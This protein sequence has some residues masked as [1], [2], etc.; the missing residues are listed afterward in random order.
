MGYTK[1]VKKQLNG[2]NI[3]SKHTSSS[4]THLLIANLNLYQ[5]QKLF[6]VTTDGSDKAIGGYISQIDATGKE[7]IIDYYS[8]IK[9]I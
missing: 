1:K 8:K 2:T 6:V 5:M 3:S 4:K 7:E 9:Q